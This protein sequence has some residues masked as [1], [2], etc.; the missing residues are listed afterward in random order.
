MVGPVRH[1]PRLASPGGASCKLWRD[2]PLS[3]AP[4]RQ[5]P[6]ARRRS[7]H[8]GRA[9]RRAPAGPSPWS[10]TPP[11]ARPTGSA[12][13]TAPA[14]RRRAAREEGCRCC[15]YVAT[16]AAANNR[17]AVPS[18]AHVGLNEDATAVVLPALRRVVWVDQGSKPADVLVGRGHGADHSGGRGGG[19][20][21]PPARRGQQQGRTQRR[22]PP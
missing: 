21:P 16:H 14:A 5:T 4:G 8:A 15:P 3:P 10:K 19:R 20:P 9:S 13:P 17:V 18:P 11:A 7:S 12:P 6:R 22:K 1:A 2:P